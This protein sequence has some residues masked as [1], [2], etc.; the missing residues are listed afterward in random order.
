MDQ[1]R[2]CE[3]QRSGSE[4][5]NDNVTLQRKNNVKKKLKKFVQS[6]C[7]IDEILLSLEH[8]CTLI[9]ESL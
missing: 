3:F 5:I 1:E 4:K 6:D 2:T 7:D 9:L 8:Y